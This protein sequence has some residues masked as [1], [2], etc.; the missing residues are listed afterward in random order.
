MEKIF[1]TNWENVVIWE[2]CPE[3]FLLQPWLPSYR[4]AG[5]LLPTNWSLQPRLIETR[6]CRLHLLRSNKLLLAL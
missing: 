3:M 1:T 6:R 5:G 4:L 2:K